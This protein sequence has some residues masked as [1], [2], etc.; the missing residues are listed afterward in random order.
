MWDICISALQHKR[1][2]YLGSKTRLPSIQ[3]SNLCLVGK[4]FNIVLV[5]KQ[6]VDVDI[7]RNLD[8]YGNLGFVSSDETQ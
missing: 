1:G 7:K 3:Q 4:V 5:M 6:R 8:C 2:F